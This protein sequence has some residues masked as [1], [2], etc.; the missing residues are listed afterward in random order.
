MGMRFGKWDVRSLYRTCFDNLYFSPNII[1][2]MKSRRMRW[3]WHVPHEGE[4]RKLYKVIVGKP[5]GKRPLDRPRRRWEDGI[6]MVI[7]E[8]G[9]GGVDWINLA[10]DRDRWRAFVSTVINLRVLT[11]RR[12]C[13]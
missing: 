3:A 7:R 4:E 10:H 8:T 5:E 2:Q 9:W 13:S 11:P 12:Y 1:S 6:K